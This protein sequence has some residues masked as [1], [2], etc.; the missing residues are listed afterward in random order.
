MFSFCYKKASISNW[1]L[2]KFR[3][4]KTN[5]HTDTTWPFHWLRVIP[6]NA[7]L[8]TDCSFTHCP[9]HYIDSGWWGGDSTL[10]RTLVYHHPKR[11]TIQSAFGWSVFQWS[12]LL[13][14]CK[15]NNKIL[16]S[17]I[18]RRAGDSWKILALNWVKKK[19]NLYIHL[20]R[21]CEK[22]YCYTIDKTETRLYFWLPIYI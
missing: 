4:G 12:I 18:Q 15:N 7:V 1:F 2:T 8:F 6:M 3:P 16:C 14:L 22:S 13:R 10:L 20:L 9:I 11:G 21:M 5:H 19:N 17:I